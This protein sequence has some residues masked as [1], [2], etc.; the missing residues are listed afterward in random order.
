MY[1]GN[2]ETRG[3]Q[4]VRAKTVASQ[5]TKLQLRIIALLLVPLALVL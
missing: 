3:P 1:D 4:E 2:N 5:V